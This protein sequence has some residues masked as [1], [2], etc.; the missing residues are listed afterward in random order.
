MCNCILSP[1]AES[2][3]FEM[4]S[5]YLVYSDGRVWS[6]K[7]NKYI[8][9]SLNNGT[10]CV[11][12]RIPGKKSD[13]ISVNRLVYHHFVEKIDFFN[14][15]NNDS[16]IYPENGNPLDH[17]YLNL[18]KRSRFYKL[19]EKASE[20]ILRGEKVRGII[21]TLSPKDEA[22]IHQK[23]LNGVKIKDIAKEY[24]VVEMTIYRSIVRY[25]ESLTINKKP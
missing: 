5:K 21:N 10:C 2:K 14:T 7:S 11:R 3:E 1:E 23:K 20:K 12:I 4:D 17:L 8:K 15:G 16:V 22:D 18:K 25:K 6:K 9:H 19:K 24:N 13:N